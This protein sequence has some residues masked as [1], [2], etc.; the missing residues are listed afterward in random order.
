EIVINAARGL[1]ED[2]VSGRVQ[3]VELRLA[4]SGPESEWKSELMSDL[5]ENLD[6][7]H[8]RG[9]LLGIERLYGAPQD[10][11][12]CHDGQRFWIL[13]ARPVTAAARPPSPAPGGTE[14][15]WT[16][17]NLIE[18][19]PEISRQTLYAYET[20]LNRGQGRFMGRLLDP[21]LGPMFKAFHGRLY[22]N[23]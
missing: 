19:L 12:W 23:L 1:G 9:L 18:V 17:A 16:R 13:Q 3:A 2:L 14:V 20:M 15:E 5:L 6:L 8:L 7:R 4:K 11:E 21:K 22:M 10:V